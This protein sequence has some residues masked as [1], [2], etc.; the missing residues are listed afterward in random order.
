MT[1]KGVF[2]STLKKSLPIKLL[3]ITNLREY[4]VCEFFLNVHRSYIVSLNRSPSQ[5]SDECNH[6][7]KSFEQLIAHLNSFKHHLLLITGDF[8]A[9]FSIWWFGDVDN[10]KGKRLESITSF[11][12]LH[13]IINE[14]T[15]IL[16]SS[17]SCIDL[18]FTNQPNIN[19]EE[20]LLRS[21]K[22]ANTR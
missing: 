22:T 16:Q 15:H 21:T 19:E 18:V 5:S 8:N 3:N 4:L 20:C 1:L 14:P 6:F 17:S 11:H 2:A 12:E 13:E 7:T 9:R 10:T